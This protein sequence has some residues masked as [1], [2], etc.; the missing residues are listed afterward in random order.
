[1]GVG[2][3][4]GAGLEEGMEGGKQK[5]KRRVATR[6]IGIGTHF[7]STSRVLNPGIQTDV[8]IGLDIRCCNHYRRIPDNIGWWCARGFLFYV[9]K[10]SLKKG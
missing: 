9:K 7:A 4:E 10:T 3:T 2:E 1:M 8:S 6:F 5:Q